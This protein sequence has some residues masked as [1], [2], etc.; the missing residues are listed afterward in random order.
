MRGMPRA[1]A[2]RSGWERWRFPALPLY[3]AVGM[4]SRSSMGRRSLPVSSDSPS[5]AAHPDA[6]SLN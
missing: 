1:D 2:S 6:L 4:D 3:R 5:G